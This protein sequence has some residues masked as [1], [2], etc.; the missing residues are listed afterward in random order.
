MNLLKPTRNTAAV[1]PSSARSVRTSSCSKTGKNIRA[2]DSIT[3]NILGFLDFQL[4]KCILLGLGVV[5]SF[6]SSIDSLFTE[7]AKKP[8]R[9]VFGQEEPRPWETNLSKLSTSLSSSS[10]GSGLLG[11][12]ASQ[13]SVPLYK[14][15][16]RVSTSRG[17]PY[18]PL[19]IFWAFFTPPPARKM[20]S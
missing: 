2:C 1:G 14:D 10:S 16:R 7:L 19:A 5:P 11:R 20:T 6:H 8:C 17:R 15:I 12:S 18:N 3:V 13:T 4:T 9:L